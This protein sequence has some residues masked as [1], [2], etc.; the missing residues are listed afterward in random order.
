MGI[1]RRVETERLDLIGGT[2]AKMRL[3]A[4]LVKRDLRVFHRALAQGRPKTTGTRG[5]LVYGTKNLRKKTR[6][7]AP[8]GLSS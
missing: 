1:P 3:C 7:E 5:R 6:P 2:G 8:R 4:P